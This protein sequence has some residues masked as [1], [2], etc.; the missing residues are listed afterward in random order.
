MQSV[1]T[2]N[3]ESFTVIKGKQAIKL[4]G[5]YGK[6][7]VVIITTKLNQSGKV[8]TPLVL[9]DGYETDIQNISPESIESFT[10]LKEQRAIELY[11]EHGK[12]G[13]VIITTKKQ[14]C[15]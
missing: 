13:V 5:E 7:G 1:S 8:D 11:G 9:V 10:I 15:R 14:Q 4:Y 2:E 12:N 3:I 6:N